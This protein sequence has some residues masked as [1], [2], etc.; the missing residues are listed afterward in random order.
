[1]KFFAK[2]VALSAGIF[3]L[4][5]F[6]QQCENPAVVDIPDGATATLDAMLEAQTGVRTYLEDMEVYLACLNEEIEAQDDDTPEEISSLMIDRYNNGVT[7]METV[8]E[9]FNDQRVAYQEANA[10]E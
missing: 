8:A 4:P 2:F 3:A 5:V 6:A 7:E 9:T 1:M 10:S